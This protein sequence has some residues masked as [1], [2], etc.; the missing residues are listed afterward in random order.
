MTISG[1]S[2]T[3]PIYKPVEA[4]DGNQSV[5]YVYRTD[6]HTMVARKAYFEIDGSP[7]GTLSNNGY[8]YIVAPPGRH[9]ISQNWT[10]WL[11][12]DSTL[13]KMLEI[14]VNSYSS[15]PIFIELAP[16]SSTNRTTLTIKWVL[17]QVH[18]SVGAE[19]IKSC[20]LQN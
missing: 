14:E 6:S 9:K 15:K 4:T 16:E 8:M 10:R 1:C 19:K 7:S 11:F 17:K 5:I 20:R 3:G 2:A 12:D 13:Q 18:E